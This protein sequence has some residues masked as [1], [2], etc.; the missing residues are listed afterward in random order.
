MAAVFGNLGSLFRRRVE[1]KPKIID[2]C[3][4]FNEIDLLEIRMGELW[5]V[6][7]RFVVI[8]SDL[9]FAGRPK[10]FFFDAYRERFKPF[11]EKITYHRFQPS[12]LPGA[13]GLSPKT[14]AER[15]A[16]EALQRDAA[17]NALAAIDAGDQDIAVLCDVDEI[18]RPEAV[19]KLPGRLQHNR[20][21]IFELLNYRGYMNSLSDRAL[22]GVTI[23]GP[24]AA[25]CKTVRRLG[26]HQVRRGKERAGHVLE[27][28]DSRWNYL[29]N[30][31]W[32][33]SST[34]GTQAFWV[35]AQNFAHIHDPYRV[36]TVPDQVQTVQV[37]EGA[38]SR[39][40]SIAL[41][42]QYLANQGDPR[43]SALSY[44]EFRIEQDIPKYMRRH[45][46]RFRRFFFFTDLAVQMPGSHTAQ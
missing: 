43:F 6:V 33:I 8:E 16:L 7:D 25:R 31:G 27:R 5:D 26:A 41:Q 44:D 42:A 22:N 11:Q 23:V 18:P 45:K 28:R 14:M 20:F 46:E 12:Q 4:L 13:H 38:I 19:A 29:E 3:V 10:P 17:G 30:G 34:G 40:E 37:F 39:D 36:V 2:V 35:K 32:H 24:V 9:S 15:F 21:C 1:Q